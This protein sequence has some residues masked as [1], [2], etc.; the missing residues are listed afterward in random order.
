MNGTWTVT[1]QGIHDADIHDVEV[2]V[3]KIFGKKKKKLIK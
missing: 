1:I 2:E 3:L